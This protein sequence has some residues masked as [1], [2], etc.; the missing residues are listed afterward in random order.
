[1]ELENFALLVGGLV[2]LVLGGE[3]LVRGAEKIA[4]NLGISPLV[5]G[6]TV[7]AFGTSAPEL[8]T[9]LTAVL[10]DP[11]T[12]GDLATGNIVGSNICNLALVLGA[13]ALIYPISIQ[14]Q[15]IKIDWT[16]A[17]GSSVLLFFFVG[18]DQQITTYEG[19]ILFS[20]LLAYT[21]YLIQSSRKEQAEK[22]ED[23]DEEKEGMSF[24]TISRDL[25]F[26]ALGSAG[27]YFGADWFVRGASQIAESFG[28]SKTVI[29]LTVVAFGTS[30]PELVASVIAASKKDTDMAIGNLLGSCIF[31]I[32][33]ILGITSIV[34]NLKVPDKLIWNGTFDLSNINF[35]EIGDI[36]WMLAITLVVLPMMITG[37]RISRKEGVIL[38][39]IYGS[40]MYFISGTI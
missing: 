10:T 21:F 5:V 23:E 28:I 30:L 27:L 26:I 9:S 14:S 32:L 33:S 6:L 35:F 7:V 2:F 19:I 24:K 34:Q 11:A 3:F 38:L 31:N 20:I 13:T 25:F 29:G 36:W 4:E 18:F 16:M 15:S 22:G 8:I 1:M 17:M 37:R 39:G 12:G 40:Y